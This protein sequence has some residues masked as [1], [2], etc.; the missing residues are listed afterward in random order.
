[1][2]YRNLEHF[3]KKILSLVMKG[4]SKT[5]GEDS[6]VFDLFHSPYTLP[7][8]SLSV[9]TGLNF[10]VAVHNWFSPDDHSIYSNHKRSIKYTSIFSLMFTLEE[11]SICEGLSIDEHVNAICEDPTPASGTSSVM[12]H[13]IPIERQHY[14]EDGPP[15]QTKVFI[16][17]E[18][19][20]LLCNDISCS[21]CI[22]QERSLGKMRE[23]KAKQ[24]VEPLKKVFWE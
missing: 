6:V 13:T 11:A 19:C 1:M 18:Q 17:S 10:S 12:R 5:E 21:S 4:W 9:T 16:R 20:E 15:F 24:A 3:K 7:K 14:E 23:N 8:L 2:V 22:K